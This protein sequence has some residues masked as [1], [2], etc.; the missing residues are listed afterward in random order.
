MTRGVV[1]EAPSG[2]AA[3]GRLLRL[4]SLVVFA[5]LAGLATAGFFVTRSA[6]RQEERRILHERAGEVAALLTSS[7]DSLGSTLRLLGEAYAARRAPGPGFTSSARSLVKGGV[8]GVGVA[9]KTG[10][11]LVVR[12]VEGSGPGVGQPLTSQ[13][14]QLARRALEAKDLVSALV[15][16]P[17]SART[18]LVLAVG[19]DDGLVVFE[20]SPVDPTRPVPSTA[21]SPFRE[22]NV[23]LYRSPQP[24]REELVI[25]T[26]AKLAPPGTVDRR[27]LKVG[28][29][30]WLLLTSARGSLA[31]SLPRTIPWI[32]LGVGLGAALSVAFVVELLTRR[33]QYALVLVSQRT[34]S[35]REA[36]GELQSARETAEEANATKNEFLSRMSHELRTPL[37]AVLG[38]AQLLELD[39]LG[40]DQQEAVGH[41]LKG[42]H[43]L[44][45]LI[46]E[47]LDIS[48]IEAGRLDLSPEAVL[49]ANLLSDALDL[50]RPIA[51]E[52]SVHLLGEGAASCDSY[53]FADRQRLLQVMLN[54]LANAVKYNRTGGSVAVS[55]EQPDPGRVRINVTDTGP[56][57]RPEHLDALFTPFERLGAEQT[58]VEGTGIGLAL[59]RRLAEAMGG[60]LDVASVPG[61]GS[62]FWVELPLVEGPVERYERLNG[63]RAEPGR[64]PPEG[65]PRHVVLHIEDNLSNLKL[66]ERI[67][68]QRSEI[69]VIAAMQGRLG[70]ELARE[71]HPA[72]IL[73]D[74]HL[75]D[76]GGDRVL[77]QLRDD[78][79]TAAIPVIIVSADATAGQIQRL[80]TAGATA[81]LTKP[82]DVRELLRLLDEALGD[83]AAGR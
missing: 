69:E 65:G 16:D 4:L 51:T 27:V 49:V 71:H 38:F 48:R 79:A 77:Q 68:A 17:A 14:G 70:L 32:I 46:D 81:Y 24:K 83:A 53:V 67:L 55:C 25:T 21:N 43:H 3:R 47:V 66:L 72:L 5:A 34:A 58:T 42:G 19:R 45:S 54:L 35:L 11:D 62:T 39:D 56:G 13:R 74:L 12:A 2:S 33:R 29:D 7:T 80:L 57:I 6:A 82:L 52:R 44:L 61:Q 64:A 22:L 76:M 8:T 73:L 10:S 26:T 75:P 37:N 9:E 1:N 60:I 41:I 28:A 20:E 31:G 78:P 15:K 30:R 36:L 40:D 18:T 50:V 59:S 63:G 23:V